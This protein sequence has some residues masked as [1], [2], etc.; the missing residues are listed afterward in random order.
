MQNLPYTLI[1]RLC[2][3]HYK[4]DQTHGNCENPRTWTDNHS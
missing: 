2:E 1:Q 3:E 4:E